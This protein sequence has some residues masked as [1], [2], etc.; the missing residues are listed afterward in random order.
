LPW[1]EASVIR[2]EFVAPL[3]SRGTSSSPSPGLTEL[4]RRF[5]VSRKTAYKWLARYDRGDRELGDRPRRPARSPGKCPAELESRV[6]ELRRAHPAWG[7]RKL[8]RVL[9]DGDEEGGGVVAGGRRR[10]ARSG[11]SSAATG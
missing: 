11:G 1:R 9:L 10:P 4:C 8:R 3:R 2:L 5:G 7:P 6:V